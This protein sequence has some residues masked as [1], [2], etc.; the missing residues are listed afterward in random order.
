MRL[1]RRTNPRVLA[2]AFRHKRVRRK[3]CGTSSCPRI[4][5]R[6]SLKHIYA[7]M[8]DDIEGRTIVACSTLSK[9]IREQLV[10]LKSG[11][12]ASKAIGL[13]LGKSALTKGI[14]TAVFDRSGYRY[15]GRIAALAA[16]IRE[17]GVKC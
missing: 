16:G 8:I 2:R 15:H 1:H 11:M 6:K 10:S 7:Q 3:L 9:D 5:V 14:S 13:N 12:E 17:A 4:S